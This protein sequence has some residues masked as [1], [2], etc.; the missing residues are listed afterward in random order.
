MKRQS[1]EW[2]KMFAIEEINNGLISEICEQV[3]QFYVKK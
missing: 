2:E 3:M 1:T